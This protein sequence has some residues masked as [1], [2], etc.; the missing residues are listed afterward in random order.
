MDNVT[1]VTSKSFLVGWRKNSVQQKL[2]K[3]AIIMIVM[4]DI[5]L[6]LMF[7]IMKSYITFPTSLFAWKNENWE[8]WKN[9]SKLT[10]SMLY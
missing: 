8:S 6:K 5:S 7:N 10:W 3:K 2:H 4:K 9:L 1:K